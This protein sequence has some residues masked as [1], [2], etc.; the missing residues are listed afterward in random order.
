MN[1]CPQH[2]QNLALLTAGVLEDAGRGPLQTHVANCPGCQVYLREITHV[3]R[4][5]SAM[6]ERLPL[7]E[8]SF[9]FHRRLTQRIEMSEAT[10]EREAGSRFIAWLITWRWRIALPAGAALLVVL[11][12]RQPPPIEVVVKNPVPALPPVSKMAKTDSPSTLQTYRLA[13]SKSPEALDELLA[14]EA[15]RSSR[16]S[17]RVT[18]MTR[19]L[20]ALTD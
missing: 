17:V 2:Q 1:P 10:S 5:H 3:C 8:P 9:D 18:A 12:N 6:V 4:D 19:D 7:V 13:A 11:A 16:S 20:E 15:A 14:R